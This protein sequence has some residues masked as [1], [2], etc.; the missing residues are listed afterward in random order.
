MMRAILTRF[1]CCAMLCVTICM[2]LPATGS[3]QVADRASRAPKKKPKKPDEHYGQQLRFGFDISKPVINLI[4]DTRRSYE[5]ELDYYIGHEVYAVAEGGF[6][7]ANYSY[8]DLSYKSTNSFLR[9]GVDRTLITRINGRDWDMAFVGVRYGVAFINR[10]EAN[11]T[12]ID[13]LWG[14][15]SGT[16][17]AK[18]FTAQWAEVTGGVRVELAKGIS[19]G[20]NIRGRFLLNEASFRELSPVFIAGFGRGDKTTVFDFNFF[21]CYAIRWGAPAAKEPAIPGQ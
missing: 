11:Y 1:F 16:I 3:A 9:A 15:T 8:P 17:P 13:S 2:L 10:Q 21:I 12:I 4:Q 20:W 18:A 19:A 7:Q 6:G 5:A 14:S